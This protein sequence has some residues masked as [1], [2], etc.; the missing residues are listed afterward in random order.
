MTY[1]PYNGLGVT[2][3]EITDC[4]GGATVRFVLG[5]QGSKF[6][7]AGVFHAVPL[8]ELGALAKLGVAKYP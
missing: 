6:V 7:D 1:K 3:V 4:A 2:G 8:S 5:I